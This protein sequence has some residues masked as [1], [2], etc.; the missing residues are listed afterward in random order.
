LDSSRS[1]LRTNL[2]NS[3][4]NNLLYN[5]RRQKDSTKLFEISDI[6]SLDNK[7]IQKKKVL[8]IIASGRVAKNYRDFSKKID[9]DYMNS[10][11]NL[12]E[13]SKK[14]N[15]KI[16]S[17]DNLDTKI[18]S[19]IVSLEIDMDDMPESINQYKPTSVRSSK[20][21]QYEPISEFPSTYRDISYSVKEPFKIKELHELILSLENNLIKDIFI[22]DYFKND[23]KNEIKIGFRLLFQH[24]KRTL[25]DDEIKDLIS[26]IVKKTTNIKN[27]DIPGL[28]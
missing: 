8:C 9:L 19:A 15:F 18:K 24:T 11:F 13:E 21:V 16:I 28:N 22:F 4:I 1:F 26:D 5:E 7:K 27:V 25:R 3:L 23:H 14:L 17:R 12:S 6:Y 2:T 20:F 10:I